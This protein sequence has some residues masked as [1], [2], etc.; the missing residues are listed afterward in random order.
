M[1]KE[2]RRKKEEKNTTGLPKEKPRDI[3]KE[4]Q[5][6]QREQGGAREAQ[7]V[8]TRIQKK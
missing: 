6:I 8:S 5:T 4:G 1:D 7:K 2:K 3:A